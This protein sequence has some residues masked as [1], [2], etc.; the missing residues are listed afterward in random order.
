MPLQKNQ[1]VI[2]QKAP[3]LLLNVVKDEYHLTSYEHWQ[4]FLQAHLRHV[5]PLYGNMSVR[6]LDSIL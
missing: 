4:Q 6:K 5:Y 3:L 1:S 2:F